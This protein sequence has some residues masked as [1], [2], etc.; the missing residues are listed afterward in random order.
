MDRRRRRRVL[1]ELNELVLE[2]H[3]AGCGGEGLAD[4]EGVRRAHSHVQPAR[5]RVQVAEKPLHAVDH[6]RP[7][8]L[9]GGPQSFRVGREEVRRSES[10]RH[11]PGGESEPAPAG[12]VETRHP[13]RQR[14]AGA[15]VDEIGLL[16][17]VEPREVVPGT[18]PEASIGLVRT[19]DRLRL[20]S[21]HARGAVRPQIRPRATEAEPGVCEWRRIGREPGPELPHGIV[22]AQWVG[23]RVD[24]GVRSPFG[25]AREYESR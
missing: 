7:A 21:E 24:A 13:V 15:R 5:L 4:R 2:D 1:D 8:G 20:D 10:V 12:L 22:Q 17:H 19:R 23:H 18:V 9:A 3:L 14:G 25:A 11:L 16:Q 6:A